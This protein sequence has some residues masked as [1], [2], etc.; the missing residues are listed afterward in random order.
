MRSFRDPTP[1]VIGQK[2]KAAAH[3]R[4]HLRRQAFVK[5]G[6]RMRA[7]RGRFTG[8]GQDQGVGAKPVL[9]GSGG[10]GGGWLGGGIKIRRF[11]LGFKG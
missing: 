5:G 11:L 9:Q 3:A 6:G 10:G 1:G 2:K 8:S 7:D 4:G